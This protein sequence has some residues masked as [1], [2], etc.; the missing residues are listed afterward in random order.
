[1]SSD[2]IDINGAMPTE[3]VISDNMVF[4]LDTNA[5]EFSGLGN[6][7]HSAYTINTQISGKHLS[8]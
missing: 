8:K 4:K 3:M 7:G 1:M 2:V 5:R 6:F